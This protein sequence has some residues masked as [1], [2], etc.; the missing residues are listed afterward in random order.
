MPNDKP[1]GS[2]ENQKANEQFSK[3]N[4]DPKHEKGGNE[5]V[6]V[7]SAKAVKTVKIKFLKEHEFAS[8]GDKKKYEKGEYANVEAHIANKLMQ[9]QI[10]FVIA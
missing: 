2:E 6:V 8:G 5:A 4:N 10:A 3:E 9:R 7:V 1:T